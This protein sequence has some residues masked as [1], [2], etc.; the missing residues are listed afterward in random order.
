MKRYF[1]F[2]LLIAILGFPHSTW[3]FG[4]CLPWMPEGVSYLPNV[5]ACGN[6]AAVVLTG[7]YYNAFSVVLRDCQNGD[8]DPCHRQVGSCGTNA[9][10]PFKVQKILTASIKRKNK[11]LPAQIHCLKERGDAQVYN[12]VRRITIKLRNPASTPSDLLKLCLNNRKAVFNNVSIVSIRSSRPAVDLG[13]NSACI[14]QP[15]LGCNYSK[16]CAF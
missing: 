10:S 2:F 14:H 11:V 13:W 6:K 7:P 4:P 15:Y 16:V 8:R 1:N 5:A 12:I 9:S 3:A